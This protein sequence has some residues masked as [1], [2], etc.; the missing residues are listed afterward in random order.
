MPLTSHIIAQMDLTSGFKNIVLN[1]T[2]LAW[3]E[4]AQIAFASFSKFWS[5]V[6][7]RWVGLVSLKTNVSETAGQIHFSD[8]VRCKGHSHL[9]DICVM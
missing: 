7:E 3:P 1:E 6:C 2:R 8:N 4:T 9:S 5:V